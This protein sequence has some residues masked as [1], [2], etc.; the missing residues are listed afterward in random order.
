MARKNI[1]HRHN[2]ALY[3]P[4][5]GQKMVHFAYI[6]SLMRSF[7]IA[8]GAASAMCMCVSARRIGFVDEMFC[9]LCLLSSYPRWVPG[10]D[11][12]TSKQ[13][14]I[15]QRWETRGPLLHHTRVKLICKWLQATNGMCVCVCV[16][17]RIN[18]K[19][20][21]NQ[22]KSIGRRVS[23]CVVF[24]VFVR[25]F[26]LSRQSAPIDVSLKQFYDWSEKLTALSSSDERFL[27]TMIAHHFASAKS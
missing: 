2:G 13:F 8:C 3:R 15:R 5:C 16:R 4:I 27:D 24:T 17:E 23:A 20:I 6:I 26:V 9:F 21:N 11:V 1:C 12:M 10:C 14:C 18:F 7:A 22:I 25:H 19:W